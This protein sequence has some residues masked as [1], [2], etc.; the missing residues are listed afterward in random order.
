MGRK[1]RNLLGR[2]AEP[3]NLWRAYLKARR[4][5]RLSLEHLLFQEHLAANIATLS[6]ELLLGEYKQ[7]E[8]RQ[9][10]VFEP[11][12]RII[13]ALPFRDRVVQH[14]ICNVLEPIFEK[15]FLPNS[16]ACRSERGTHMAARDVQAQLRRMQKK[17]HA[18]FLKT[19]FSK[20]FASINRAKLHQAIRAKISCSGTLS[21]LKKIIPHEGWGLPIGSLTSQLFANLYGHQVDS[22]LVHMVGEK[23]FVRYMDD[24]VLLGHAPEYLHAL[25]I[26][27]SWFAE[28]E[29][30]LR[31]S[32]W[33]V[34]PA[35]RGINFV[36][37]RIW[38]THKLLRKSSVQRAKRKLKVLQGDKRR[39]FLVAWRG[40][41]RHADCYHLLQSLKLQD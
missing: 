30:G 28:A 7:G 24:I 6:S 39:R 1:Y 25:R 35:S 18:W 4:G 5:K 29:L 36:G 15:I 21:L 16:Y 32:H 26:R 20:Y 31:F 33:Q 8:F 34:A 14:A 2:I 9:F 23:C 19:D 3:D 11:K 10:E 12:R 40:H 41:A 22:W 27:L 37:Y 13:S 17:G 38:S